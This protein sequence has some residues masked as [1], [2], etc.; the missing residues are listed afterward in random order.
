MFRFYLRRTFWKTAL[1]RPPSW[2]T[3]RRSSPSLSPS[4]HPPLLWRHFRSP[5]AL[6]WVTL[7][8]SRS[9]L[10]QILC[11]GG[12]RKHTFS[13]K[14]DAK[15]IFSWSDCTARHH[16]ARLGYLYLYVCAIPK[17]KKRKTSV[18]SHLF[19]T[20]LA[21]LLLLLISCIHWDI[22]IYKL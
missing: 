16:T 20:S 11:S 14:F 7:H 6:I 19:H 9:D 5:P 15:G 3:P 8:A 10:M 13:P 1:S 21:T 22:L 12:G 18:K 17:S 4:H 2:W